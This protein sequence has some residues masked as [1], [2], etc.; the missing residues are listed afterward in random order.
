MLGAAAALERGHSSVVAP[1]GVGAFF[2]GGGAE[3]RGQQAVD[4]ALRAAG[5]PW[6][7]GNSLW[8]EP[9]GGA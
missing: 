6:L 7:K 4:D 8:V 9:P 3:W 2:A 1:C 5:D